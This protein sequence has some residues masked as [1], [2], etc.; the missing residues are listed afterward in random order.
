[1]DWQLLARLDAEQ[2][3]SWRAA[4]LAARNQRESTNL[5]LNN[6]TSSITDKLNISNSLN[7]M[8][9]SGGFFFKS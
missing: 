9:A 1:M 6:V 5:M 7:F 3:A 2:S 4:D 8:S